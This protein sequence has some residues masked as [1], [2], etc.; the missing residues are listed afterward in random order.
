MRRSR[1][2][3][4]KEMWLLLLLILLPNIATF[5]VMGRQNSDYFFENTGISFSQ[6]EPF[7]NRQR[8]FVIDTN[9]VTGLA[10][11]TDVEF[12]IVKRNVGDKDIVLYFD[13]T[14][15][16]PPD[17]GTPV[18]LILYSPGNRLLNE[19]RT[20]AIGGRVQQT[21]SLPANLPRGAYRVFVSTG[22]RP[23]MNYDC[24]RD[25]TFYV[26]GFNLSTM[27]A[28]N[29]LGDDFGFIP[30]YGFVPIR[31]SVS[32][33]GFVFFGVENT[34]YSFI[35]QPWGVDDVVQEV[36]LM[37][38]NDSSLSMSLVRKYSENF[39]RFDFK[40]NK[41]MPYFLHIKSYNDPGVDNRIIGFRLSI[42]NGVQL[43]SQPIVPLLAF[44]E[45]TSID[46]DGDL[47]LDV[48]EV[49]FGTNPYSA[50]TD[51]DSVSDYIE[52]LLGTDPLNSSSIP[53]RIS[54]FG[55]SI[56]QG[57]ELFSYSLRFTPLI[58]LP[59]NVQSLTYQVVTHPSIAL[60]DSVQATVG[61][62]DWTVGV[63][64][65]FNMSLS[66]LE[67]G[68]YSSPNLEFNVTF[69][70]VTIDDSPV[71]FAVGGEETILVVN[72]PLPHPTSSQSDEESSNIEPP[73]IPLPFNQDSSAPSL[74]FPSFQ[75]LLGSIAI[76]WTSR[77]RKRQ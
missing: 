16:A 58:P 45:N 1:T 9:K 4:A 67:D 50:D 34:S 38:L 53:Y 10:E 46:S 59:S 33:M 23:D 61:N 69:Q 29:G 3:S 74:P 39:V 14:Y 54:S 73:S 13:G 48:E 2:N 12:I 65:W 18:Q 76:V 8:Y 63:P 27:L 30:D 40:I 60:N 64:Q 57:K 52:Q 15:N 26:S 66:G 47:I 28:I 37:P 72:T 51:E 31:N 7:T 17:T 56:V 24:C 68:K 41:T 20:P 49:A 22:P 6:S 43:A 75:L 55:P 35:H 62:I 42:D 77:K 25:F 11:R 71:S 19:W 21:I 70:G 44:E 36:N 5:E 32:D